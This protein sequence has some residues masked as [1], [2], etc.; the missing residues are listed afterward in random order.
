MSGWH[1]LLSGI[2]AFDLKHTGCYRVVVGFNFPLGL[3]RIR[4][5]SHDFATQYSHFVDS[6]S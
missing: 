2:A 5:A 1:S 3:V 4:H 6:K